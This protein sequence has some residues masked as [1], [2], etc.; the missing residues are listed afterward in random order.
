[1]S[2]LLAERNGV[3]GAAADAVLL[4]RLG[5]KIGDRVTVGDRRRSRSAA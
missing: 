1:M 5:L 3:F 2:E 4:A